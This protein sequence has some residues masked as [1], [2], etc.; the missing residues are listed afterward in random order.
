MRRRRLAVETEQVV[1]IVAH[2]N[3]SFHVTPACSFDLKR[4]KRRTSVV[5]NN[6][7]SNVLVRHLTKATVSYVGRLDCFP[8]QLTQHP[9]CR[10]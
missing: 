8:I 2:L 4:D 6:S 10:G 5:D 1:A 7:S 9:R 3:D